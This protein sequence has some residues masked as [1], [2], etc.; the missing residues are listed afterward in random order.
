MFDFNGPGLNRV[1]SVAQDNVTNVTTIVFESGNWPQPEPQIVFPGVA[2]ADGSPLSDAVIQ[3][4]SAGRYWNQLELEAVAAKQHWSLEELAAGINRLAGNVPPQLDVFTMKTRAALFGHNAPLWSSLPASSRYGEWIENGNSQWVHVPGAYGTSWINDP[5]IWYDIAYFGGLTG[6]IDLD[7]VYSGITAGDWIA[8]VDPIQNLSSFAVQVTGTREVSRTGY[9]LTARITRVAASFPNYSGNYGLRRSKVLA[10]SGQ[11]PVAE[12]EITADV[13]G[14][15]ILLDHAVFGLRTGQ[16]LV[17][18]GE[19]S[20]KR[21]VLASEVV[22]ISELHL[23]DGRTRISLL[24]GLMHPYLRD[25]VSINAN[26]ALATHGDTK[27]EIL[28][29]GDASQAFQ[30]FVMKQPP[31]TWISADTPSL[32]RSTLTVHVNGLEWHEVETLYGAGPQDRVFM[33][34]TD[35]QGRTVVQFG[36]GITGARLPTGSN[37]VQ[38]TYRQGLGSGGNVKAG[39]LSMLMSRPLGLHGVTNPLPA[40]GGEDPETVAQSRQNAPFTVRTLDRI[41]SLADYEDFARASAGIAK[42]SVSWEWHG[43]Q[44]LVFLTISGPDGSAITSG[45]MLYNALLSSIQKAGDP[46]I[47]ILV[48]SYRPVSFQVSAT[49]TTDPDRITADV[50]AA[51]KDALRAK[52]SFEQRAFAAPVFLSDVIATMQNVTGV[53]SVN[54]TQLYRSGKAPD[55]TPPEYLLADGPLADP[56]NPLGAELLTIDTGLLTGIQA[57]L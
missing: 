14:S 2:P 25:T 3:D 5:A 38:A 28:G 46:S 12:I 48:A 11:L 55:P 9:S 21:G 52:F 17:V 29:S 1:S 18:S 8:L 43:D 39:A 45:S 6:F 51:V 57:G 37:N 10:Q 35:E 15:V 50:L 54:V 33:L 32:S 47:P 56:N 4:L 26:V 42:A 23:E 53:I 34:A 41:V 13:S 7:N 19:R 16:S 49:V 20:D 44:R 40:S 30:S 27:Q 22:T 31:L 36:D 24:K